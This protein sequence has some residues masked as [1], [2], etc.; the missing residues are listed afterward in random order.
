MARPR[1]PALIGV[2]HLPPLAGAPKA[3]GAHPATL[4]EK[5]GLRA[6]AEAKILDREGFDGIVLENFGDAPFY[7]DSVPPE[8][9][10]CMSVIA[11]AI[12]QVTRASV[13]INVLRNDARAALAIASVTDCEF[14]RVNVLSGLVAADQGL[15][16]GNA[17]FLLR[18][19]E[20]LGARPWIFADALV[21]HAKT[22]SSDSV[23][24]VIHDLASRSGA[25][26]VVAS[27]AATGRAAEL[28]HVQAAARAARSVKVP[29]YLGSGVTR[30]NI[31]EFRP[32]IEGVIVSSDLRQ[33]GRAGAPLEASRVRQF[34]RAFAAA[35]R[36]ARKRS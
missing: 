12:R 20:R 23:G 25:D 17:A 29:L 14:I 5:A 3:G 15:I 10:A 19:R 22:L 36:A 4:L 28:S 31:V 35:G 6:V 18:E 30:E 26:A 33:G 16:E 21:K 7:K 34:S 1:F 2:I 27:G 32:W 11:G 9:I 24:T 13:G 8:T